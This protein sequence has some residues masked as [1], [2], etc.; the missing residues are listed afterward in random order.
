MHGIAAPEGTGGEPTFSAEGF[1]DFDR[2][3][4]GDG[5]GDVVAVDVGVEIDGGTAGVEA[6]EAA[7]AHGPVVVASSVLSEDGPGR[8]A[9]DFFEHAAEAGADFAVAADDPHRLAVVFEAEVGNV[10]GDEFRFVTGGTVELGEAGLIGFGPRVFRWH[11]AAQVALAGGDAGGAPET[12]GLGADALLEGADVFSVH[13][14]R[15]SGLGVRG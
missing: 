15:G 7:A 3:G 8:A 13:G 14:G 1:H 10:D 2:H 6:G 5:P 12:V 9:G 4:G 11:E